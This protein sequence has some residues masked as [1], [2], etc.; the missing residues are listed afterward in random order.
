MGRF[1]QY[2]ERE[3]M[4]VGDGAVLEVAMA[5]KVRIPLR[6]I[7]PGGGGVTVEA[8]VVAAEDAVHAAVTG[9]AAVGTGTA[10][11]GG[12]IAADHEILEGPEEAA[13][14]RRQDATGK[15]EVF[16][17][18]QELLGAG[19]V[20]DGQEV[21][22]QTFADGIGLAGIGALG[23]PALGFFPCEVTPV[24]A[25]SLAAGAHPVRAGRRIGAI[26][27][28]VNKIIEGGSS[29]GVEGGQARDLGQAGM[30]SQIAGPLGNALIVQ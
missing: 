22:G 16:Q 4:L 18:R 19:L 10:G 15:Q 13:L 5:E 29:R 26:F 17:A 28:A 27:E 7:T 12:T 24:P 14:G 20:C 30:A 11:Q 8:L 1:D 25:F 9:G 6:V 2:L 3:R 23:G 21:L